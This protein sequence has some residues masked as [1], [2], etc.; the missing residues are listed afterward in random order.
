MTMDIPLPVDC[1]SVAADLL[2]QPELLAPVFE[3][4]K[5]VVQELPALLGRYTGERSTRDEARLLLV[6]ALRLLGA[7]DREIETQ[8]GVTRRT[9]PLMLAALEQSGRITPL[10]ERLATLT[11]DNAERA[12]LAAV[13]VIGLADAAPLGELVQQ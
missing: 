10:K 13:V 5:P 7:S 9:I 1:R 3:D 6:G 2:S 8:A 4:S 11:G 12:Q